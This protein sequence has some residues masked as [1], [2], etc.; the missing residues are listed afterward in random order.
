V[1]NAVLRHWGTLSPS[2]VDD[3]EILVWGEKQRR[4]L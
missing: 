4:D 2:A 1:G 3:H